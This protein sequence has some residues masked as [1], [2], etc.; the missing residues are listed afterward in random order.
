MYRDLASLLFVSRF[1]MLKM[2]FNKG[3]SCYL[4]PYVS[5]KYIGNISDTYWLLSEHQNTM[6]FIEIIKNN[7]QTYTDNIIQ[8]Q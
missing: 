5:Q 7:I 3:Q 4:F 6:V 2:P 8:R 1:E